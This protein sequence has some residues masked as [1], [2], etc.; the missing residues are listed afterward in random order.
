MYGYQSDYFYITT[1]TR[2]KIS[3][4]FRNFPTIKRVLQ[5]DAMSPKVFIGTRKNVFR[6]VNNKVLSIDRESPS[7]LRFADDM[8]L[9]A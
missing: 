9:I 2:I 1:T 3:D 8:I 5:G 7:Y 6:K 4:D